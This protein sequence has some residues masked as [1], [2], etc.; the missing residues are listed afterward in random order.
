MKIESSSGNVFADL[1][2]DN[3]DQRQARVLT[4]LDWMEARMGTASEHHTDRASRGRNNAISRKDGRAAVA[5]AHACAAAR[6][7]IPKLPRRLKKTM[8]RSDPEYFC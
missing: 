1:A 4:A 6:L 3:P 5:H 7:G 2:I 8:W